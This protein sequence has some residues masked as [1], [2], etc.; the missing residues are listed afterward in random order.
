[1]WTGLQRRSKD[2]D[3]FTLVE[4]L[5]VVFIIGLLA[6]IGISSFL[7]QRSKAQD[8]EAKQ[9]IR[10]ASHALQVFHMDH[11]TYNASVANLVDIEPALRSARHLVVNG[12]IN[13]YDVAVDSASGQNTYTLER[14]ADGEVLRGCTVPGSG[15][16]RDTPDD[17]GQ[18][19]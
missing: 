5:V 16:C 6:A 12:T 11:D 17:D 7:S 1:M 8:A 2:E 13:T 14:D 19:W 15:G 9:V 3:G 10:T 4:L 18:L